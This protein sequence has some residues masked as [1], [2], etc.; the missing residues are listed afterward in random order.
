M[1]CLK[2]V[3]FQ[4]IQTLATWLSSTLFSDHV[5]RHNFNF[6]LVFVSLF[7]CFCLCCCLFRC[8][9]LFV[10]FCVF[11]LLRLFLF[12][13][14][15]SVIWGMPLAIL[16]IREYDFLRGDADGIIFQVTQSAPVTQVLVKQTTLFE[17]EIWG[18][19]EVMAFDTRTVKYKIKAHY[20][21]LELGGVFA[22]CLLVCFCFVF[23]T[24]LFT[25]L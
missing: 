19:L 14:V 7:V 20:Y 22:Y 3:F 25:S 2:S 10:C 5:A 9:C 13:C 16:C 18:K 6:S 12:V 15:L 21:T 11:V 1:C 4:N 17:F 23:R 8:C 24:K